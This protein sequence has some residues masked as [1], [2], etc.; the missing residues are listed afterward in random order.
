MMTDDKGIL[1][2]NIYYM[3]SYAFVSLHK[4]NYVDIE[5]EEFENIHDMFA[6]II[7]KSVA[8][9]IKHGLYKEY[10]AK[11]EDLSVLRGN[12]NGTIRNVI[13]HKQKLSCVY[14]ELSENNLLNQIIKTTMIILVKQKNVKSEHKAILKKNLLFLANVDDIAPNSIRWDGI[15]YSRNNQSYRLIINLCYLVLSGLLITTESGNMRL[16]EF[17]DDQTMHRLYEKFLLEY[18]RYHHPEYRANPDMIPWNIDDGVRDFLP[19]MK[20]DITLKKGKKT[21]IIDAKYYE[22]TMQSFYDVNTIHSGNLYQIFAYVKNMDMNNSG[23]VA[24]ILLYA[25]TQE[26]ITP[27]VRYSIG[28]NTI[29]VKTLDLN[30]PFEQITEQLEQIVEKF[31]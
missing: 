24:G 25:K 3:M 2:K 10:I 17:L 14:D 28:G 22:H 9:Q 23:N 18:Y 29:W 31:F 26:Q 12:L 6:A 11:T 4:S 20:T 8:V 7:G 30:L 16:A 27:N 15:R 13:E 19:T 21:L 1:I 5:V